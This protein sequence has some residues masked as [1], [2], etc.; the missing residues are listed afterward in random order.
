MIVRGP[1]LG[2]PASEGVWVSAL[3]YSALLLVAAW[4]VFCRVRARLAFWV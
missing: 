4:A 1:L 2:A 3:G